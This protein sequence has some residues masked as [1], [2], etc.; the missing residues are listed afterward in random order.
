MKLLT[1]WPVSDGGF[2]DHIISR[3]ARRLSRALRSA[4]YD[5]D[6]IEQHLTIE[7]W[8]LRERFDIGRGSWEGFATQIVRTAAS[9]LLRHVRA[10][11]RNDQRTVSLSSD[12]MV[13]MLQHGV[14]LRIDLNM[15]IKKLSPAQRRFLVAIGTGPR[16][17]VRATLGI[18]RRKFDSHK[19]ALIQ[20]FASLSLDEYRS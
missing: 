17:K 4:C 19:K 11:K 15:A 16:E 7:L 5:L 9:R 13:A 8:L 1:H 20:S 10:A 18:S 3:T 14:D 6:D 2:A 12:D